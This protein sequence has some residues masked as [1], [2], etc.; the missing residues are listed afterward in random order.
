MKKCIWEQFRVANY[1]NTRC[2][3]PVYSENDYETQCGSQYQFI[4]GDEKEWGF[5]FCPFCS[6]KIIYVDCNNIKVIEYL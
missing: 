1:K 6:G 4:N 5:K 3:L 2:F